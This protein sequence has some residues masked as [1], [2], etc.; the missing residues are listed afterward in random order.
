M[1]AA[2]Y[3]KDSRTE[4]LKLVTKK[5]FTPLHIS[6]TA[7]DFLGNEGLGRYILLPGSS[8]RAKAIAAHFDQLQIRTHGRGHHL[9]L[10]N[11]KHKKK[12]IA[13]GTIATGMGCPSMEI[14]LHELLQLGAKNLLRVGTAGSLQNHIKPGEFINV[15]ASVR[16]EQTTRDYCPV[17]VPALASLSV[18]NA[19]MEAAEKLKLKMHTGVVHCKSSFYAREFGF[20]PLRDE[21]LAYLRMLTDCGVLAS[22]MET[23]T[24]FIQTQIYN[25]TAKQKVQAGAI[26]GVMGK[27]P[28]SFLSPQRGKALT[29]KLIQ[30]AIDTILCLHQKHTS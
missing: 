10:G 30:L 13:V 29:E 26:L 21:H 5:G 14:I 19:A 3:N 8:G 20:G 27:P 11:L 6:G 17:E 1:A 16:D 22:E 18:I 9:Y 24:L 4:E 12:T 2:I 25:A 28:H 23:S 7:K 15:Q